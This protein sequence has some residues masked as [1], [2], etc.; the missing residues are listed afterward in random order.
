MSNMGSLFEKWRKAAKSEAADSSIQELIITA[1]VQFR[2]G[3]V[4]TS[5]PVE[6]IW[7]NLNWVHVMA[8]DYYMPQW[9]NF[10]AAHVALYDPNSSVNTDRGFDDVEAFKVKVSY[11]RE[12]KLLGYAVWEVSYEDNWALSSAVGIVPLIREC[13]FN[14][15][16][17]P[18]GIETV[19]LLHSNIHSKS[20]AMFIVGQSTIYISSLSH[21][22]VFNFLPSNFVI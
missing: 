1:S 15:L 3:L 7:N 21:G 20:K 14:H 16:L 13:S 9:A 12:K 11:A 8:Y 17:K 19:L 5:Y 2:Q 10:T 4:S 6:S 22:T 18:E